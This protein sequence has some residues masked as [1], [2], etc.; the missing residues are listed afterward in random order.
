MGRARCR[1]DLVAHPGGDRGGDGGGRRRAPTTSRAWASPTSARRRWCGTATPASR[2]TTRS[3]GRTPAPTSSWTSSRSDG[4]QARFQ[5]Q[6]GLPLA[7]YFS[8]PKIRW[9]LDNV[10]GAREKAEA[11]D[12]LF[13]NID[14]WLIW[15][16]TGGT[17]GGLHITDVTNASRTMLMDLKTLHWDEEI[18]GIMGIP[19]AMLP[20]IKASSEVYG[21]VKAG[22]ALAGRGDRGRPRRPAGG[23]V[24]PDLLRGRRGQEHL[25]HGQL[26]AA[27]HGHRGGAV[28]ERPADDGGLQDRRPGRRV[29]PGGLDRHH[30]RAGP[31]AA[32]QPQDDQGRA[33]GRGP[34]QV[35]RRQRRLLL[36]AGVLGPVRAVLEVERARRDRRPDALRQRRPHRPGHARGDGLPEPRGRRGDER[37]LGRRRWSRSRS[38]AAWSATTC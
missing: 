33:R 30:R 22:G 15:N 32:R 3:C 6:V 21:E 8:G 27:Q 28:E 12:L 35:G 19:T 4:G 29:L 24:R 36:R 34:G 26:P 5:E 23:H 37:R 13:G 9:I 20:E 25:R 18:A 38:T 17:D 1:R 16:L 2:C 7:T 14:T 10:D 11:G 31:V